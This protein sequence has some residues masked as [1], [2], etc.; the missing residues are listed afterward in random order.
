MKDDEEFFE[1]EEVE[2]VENSSTLA[3]I[4]YENKKLIWVLIIVIILIF[5]M[6]I[7]GNSSKSN[8]KVDN[9]INVSLSSQTETISVNNTKQLKVTVNENNN[10]INNPDIIWTSSD[11]SVAI[12]DTNGNIRG[13]KEGTATITATYKDK[14]ESY[15]STCNVTVPL[16]F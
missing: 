5:L 1:D 6:L 3:S 16:T 15:T 11:S 8:N 14:D 9:K 2:K 10:R 12:V 4:Y 13:L 7:F